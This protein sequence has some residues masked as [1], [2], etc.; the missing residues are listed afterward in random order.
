[1][2]PLPRFPAGFVWGAATASYQVEGGW[3]ADGRGPSVWDTFS[4]SAGRVR[5]GDT[6]DVA[7]D[8]YHRW[9]EDVALL[10][11]LGVDA[12]RF[13]VAWP[14][15]VPTGRPADGVNDAGLD[16]YDRLVDGL[17]AAGVTPLP[18]LYHWDL[19]QALEDDGGWLARDTASRFA[20]YA[21]LVA[22]RLGDRVRR[23]ITLNEPFVQMAFGYAL[24]V[25]APGRTLLLD[26]LPAGHHQLLGH[27]LAAAALRAAGPHEVLL[28]NNC[29]PVTAAGPAGA[30]GAP[31]PPDAA[32]RAAAEAYDTLHNRLFADPVLLGR[33]PDLSAFGVQDDPPWLADGDLAVI[34]VPP[35]GLG[36]NYYTP[37]Q[38]ARPGAGSPLPF[39][40][41][42]VAAPR[43]T[44]FGWPVVPDGLRRLLVGLVERYGAALPPVW[45]TENGC[46]VDDALGPDGRVHD[47][48]RV[49]FLA[50]HLH[51]LH[52][53]LESGVDVRGWFVWSL[54]D[55]FEWAEGYSQRFGL[56][57]VDFQTGRRTPKDS[58]DW[59]RAELAA[60][61]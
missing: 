40:Q 23:W 12:Y 13:S 6:G 22:E 39:T 61:R 37:T 7:C 18:T 27:G 56:V 55:N 46:S 19:P 57:H 28:T 15:V 34:G 43:R 11:E 35:D 45:V 1:M 2:A 58:F 38:I 50:G 59:L 26:A 16:H 9:A 33:Y 60:Q 41:L 54:L 3:D 8:S 51:A 30:D 10:A 14:R 44:A 53:A 42:E 31:A 17:L 52:E 32:D 24:G 29:T 49:D 36:V 25:H 20:D 48:D 4:H 21:A 47:D 5:G